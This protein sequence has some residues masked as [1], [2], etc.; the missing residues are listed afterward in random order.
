VGEGGGGN[1]GEEGGIGG[2]VRRE[3]GWIVV[4]EEKLLSCLFA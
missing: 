2:E 3:V 4:D 1:V